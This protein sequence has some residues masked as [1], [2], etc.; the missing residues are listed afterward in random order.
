MA[1]VGWCAESSH[2]CCCCLD[3]VG[4][5]MHHGD[6]RN[7]HRHSS[8]ATISQR[9]YF[10]TQVSLVKYNQNIVRCWNSNLSRCF[11][12]NGKSFFVE[13]SFSLSAAFIIRLWF[14]S[15]SLPHWS[16]FMPCNVAPCRTRVVNIKQ[17]II[18]SNHDIRRHSAATLW[19]AEKFVNWNKKLLRRRYQRSTRSG[20]SQS[21]KMCTCAS[22]MTSPGESRLPRTGAELRM[23][24]AVCAGTVLSSAHRRA[25]RQ[26]ESAIRQPTHIQ[27]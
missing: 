17:R 14:V 16:M 8:V 1:V 9:H 25:S 7:L 23:T 3:D 20:S 10:N 12:A 4:W 18:L 13:G 2:G 27:C 22:D 11:E 6:G 15:Q 24:R 26:H 5:K 21:G 19:L